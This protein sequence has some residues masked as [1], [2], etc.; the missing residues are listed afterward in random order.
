MPADS[1]LFPQPETVISTTAAGP[2]AAFAADQLA[3]YLAII[4]GKRFRTG[5][6]AAHIALSTDESGALSPGAHSLTV[7]PEAI[8]ITGAGDLALLH[9]VYHFLEEKCG[10]RWLA[11]FEGGE[12]VPRDTE[13]SIAPCHDSH[14]PVFPHRA[15][16]NFPDIDE[17]TVEMVDWMCK[18]R[19]DRFMVFSNVEGAFERYQTVLKPHLELRGMRVEM[20]HHSFAYW[21]PPDQHFDDHP[22]WYSEFDGRRVT[23]GQLCTSNPQVVELVAERI[24]RFLTENPEIDMV[25]LWP[26]DGYRWCQ[27]PACTAVEPQRP[28][29]L[30]PHAPART[31]TYIEFVNRVAR[32]VGAAHPDR[33]LSALVYVNYVE[34]PTVDVAENIAVCFAPMARCFKHPLNAPPECARENARYAEFFSQWR[35]RV[36]G[37]LYLFCYLMLIDICSLPY[38]ITQMLGPNFKWLAENGCDGYVMEFKPEE[39]GPFGVNAHLIGRLSWDPNLD[40]EE[41]LA[42]YR[43]TLY[44]PAADEMAAFGREYRRLF[45]DPG[46]CVYH[47][48]L[49]YTRRATHELLR[50]ALDHLGRARAAAREKRHSEAVERAHIGIE[51]LMR[52]GEWQRAYQQA[53]D[54]T[55]P[56]RELLIERAVRLGEE[57][58]TWVEAH[59]DANAL[60]SPRIAGVVRPAIGRLAQAR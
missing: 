54:A 52:M 41:W 59:G 27:C 12:I 33:R 4:T 16:T 40:V 8:S 50:P 9:G 53:E 49:T 25:G 20:G 29:E 56:K 44:G 42:D 17:R 3:H 57:L 38:D 43:R 51:L 7:S 36:S 30:R 13:L 14:A 39:W 35:E 2:A 60:F 58:I 15:F 46:P 28:S 10:C 11:A 1:F 23:D 55:D 26:N 19:F 45:I 48:D 31:D 21:L 34:P 24:S 22:E 6:D 32:L 37:D 47:Y 5:D 18:N